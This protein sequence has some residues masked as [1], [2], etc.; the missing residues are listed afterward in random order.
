MTE[1]CEFLLVFAFMLVKFVR[2]FLVCFVFFLN[3]AYS[4]LNYYEAV[5][6]KDWKQSN[7][8]SD[9]LKSTLT[10]VKIFQGDSLKKKSYV[11]ISPL[12]FRLEYVNT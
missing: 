7:R 10:A 11:T 5:S 4:N 12:V 6:W 2:S 8:I 3:D 1:K 9:W